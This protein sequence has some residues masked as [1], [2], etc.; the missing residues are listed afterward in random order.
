MKLSGLV[1]GRRIRGVYIEKQYEK[2]V[3]LGLNLGNENTA[4]IFDE[5]RTMHNFM[6]L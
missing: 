6:G 4:T 1:K 5:I 3:K 2:Q